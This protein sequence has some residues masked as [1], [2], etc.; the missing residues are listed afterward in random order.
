MTMPPTPAATESLF[1]YGTLQLASVQLATF[2]RTLEGKTDQLPGFKKSMVAIGDPK[3][4]EVSGKTHH[5]IVQFTG[6]A[7]DAVSGTVF[8]ITGD[9][10][11]NADK[12]EVDAYTRISVTLGSGLRAWV[13]ID[14]RHAPPA[15]EHKG[16]SQATQAAE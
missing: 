16:D 5:P 8:Q 11:R 7:A 14:A 2:G 10:L 6:R 9:E 4:V 1:S 12:Y 3:V 13:Y 15:S